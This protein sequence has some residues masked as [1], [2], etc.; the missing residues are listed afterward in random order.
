MLCEL[1]SDALFPER[2]FW[3]FFSFF[4]FDRQYKAD[5]TRLNF[6]E[7]TLKRFTD[8]SHYNDSFCRKCQAGVPTVKNEMGYY[9]NA[10]HINYFYPCSTLSNQAIVLSLIQKTKGVTGLCDYRTDP[11]CNFSSLAKAEYMY[12]MNSTDLSLRGCPY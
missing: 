8:Y 7:D 2:H 10:L 3:F 1:S 4:C 6:C 11:A 5:I 12:R 9:P